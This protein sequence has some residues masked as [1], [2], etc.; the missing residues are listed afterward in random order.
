METAGKNDID[1]LHQKCGKD[2]SREEK[3]TPQTHLPPDHKIEGSEHHSRRSE[4]PKPGKQSAFFSSQDE[5]EA[6]E[7]AVVSSS[8]SP[9]DKRTKRSSSPDHN[10]HL[11]Q[12]ND[13]LR[14]QS[15]HQSVREAATSTT[16]FEDEFEKQ[17]HGN[18]NLGVTSSDGRPPSCGTPLGKI[19]EETSSNNRKVMLLGNAH[20]F[21]KPS[22]S[23]RNMTS[24]QAGNTNCNGE[25]RRYPIGNPHTQVDPHSRDGRYPFEPRTMNNAPGFSGSPIHSDIS[26]IPMS[27][28][29]SA[30]P[31]NYNSSLEFYMGGLSQGGLRSPTMSILSQARNLSPHHSI[32]EL[33]KLCYPYYNAHQSNMSVNG[34]QQNSNQSLPGNF[35][36]NINPLAYYQLMQQQQR[37]LAVAA[38]NDRNLA[39]SLEKQE[40]FGRFPSP[41][42][43]SRARKRPLS[44]SPCFSDTGLDITAMIR[45]SPNSLLP[46]GGLTNSRSSSVAS[47]GSYGHLAAGGI[48]PTFGYQTPMMTSPQ[49]LHAHLLSRQMQSSFAG[50]LM[51]GFPTNQGAFDKPNSRFDPNISTRNYLPHVG[52][53]AAS[54][55]MCNPH[56]DNKNFSKHS[57]DPQSPNVQFNN[58]NNNSNSIPGIS[59]GGHGANEENDVVYDTNCSWVNCSLEFDTQEQLV[60]HINNDHIHGDKKEFVCRWI[61]CA[62]DQRPFKAQYMLVVHMRR[63]TGEKPH[64]CTFEG[65][66]KAYS[67]LENLKTHLRSHTGEKPYV[68]E[69][70]SCTKAFSNASDRAKHQNRTHSNEKPYACKQAGCTK[71]YTDPSSLRKHVKTVHGPEAH[72]TKRMKAERE[73]EGKREPNIKQEPG[74]DK[75]KRKGDAGG[76]KRTCHP[77]SP[78]SNPPSNDQNPPSNMNPRSNQSSCTSGSDVSV[79]PQN[80]PHM[81]SQ[82]N[83]SGVDVNVGANEGDSDGDIVVDENPQPDSTSGGVGVQSRHRGTV[84]ASLV[85]RLVN[86]KMQNLSIGGNIESYVDIGGYDDQRKL[87]MH[88]AESFTEVSSTTAFPAKQKNATFPRKL[89]LTPH[90]QV[91]LLNQDRRDSGTVSDGSRKSSLASQNSRRSSQNTGGINV[92]GSYDPISL[93]SSRRSSSNVTSGSSALNPY[94]LHRLRSRFNEN[95]GLPPPTPVDREG[96]T[97]SQL[98]RW[99]KDD[100]PIP[101]RGGYLYNPQQRPSLPQMGPP[102]PPMEDRRRSEPRSSA[103]TPLPPHLGG[104]VAFRRASDPTRKSPQ[105]DPTRL[106]N[107]QRHNSWN[108]IHPLPGIKPQG[109]A[110]PGAVPCNPSNQP[111]MQQ[112]QRQR[113]ISNSSNYYGGESGYHSHGSNMALHQPSYQVNEQVLMENFNNDV[114]NGDVTYNGQVYGKSDHWHQQT[115]PHPHQTMTPASV[116]SMPP[117]QRFPQNGHINQ[118]PFPRSF[119]NNPNVGPNKGVQDANATRYYGNPHFNPNAQ[120]GGQVHGH[121]TMRPQ[122]MTQ[123]NVTQQFGNP[124]F[125]QLPYNAPSPYIAQRQSVQNQGRSPN[126]I[127]SGNVEMHLGHQNRTANQITPRPPVSS[128]SSNQNRMRLQ[129]VRQSGS[130]SVT[131][132]NQ[133]P[134]VTSQSNGQAGRTNYTP[135]AQIPD[136]FLQQEFIDSIPELHPETHRE[137]EPNENQPYVK[138]AADSTTGPDLDGITG[139]FCYQDDDAMSGTNTDVTLPPMSA[140]SS[141]MATPMMGKYP[142]QIPTNQH[143]ASNMAINSMS[144]MLSTLE[145]ENKYLNLLPQ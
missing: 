26:L 87:G 61:G 38:R 32:Q 107:V 95:A 67:R 89:P 71:R 114:I 49:H 24:S 140:F 98:S 80:S 10:E 69:Y 31:F 134:S 76:T 35:S 48:S 113:S 94:Q 36:Q 135:D 8:T 56:R 101:D 145:E 2:F 117:H 143:P 102:K 120:M 125:M 123:Q 5:N 30:N 12:Q 138:M 60:H 121:P 99:L 41:L 44:I 19:K 132:Y 37:L 1:V 83:D 72:V 84:R 90:R 68:C 78:G 141:R 110:Y 11:R 93:D 29:Q 103:R 70:P 105:M 22:P 142:P 119:N 17:F 46:F 92:A 3:A 129:R 65:C 108:S 97:K 144:S 118:N 21:T 45:T 42:C 55:D 18:E 137:N 33:E 4:A 111:P 115:T 14:H 77:L 25:D 128:T 131:S 27:P 15:R 82:N 139:N 73:R 86:K 40:D 74:M 34:A 63:H 81:T 43:R 16:T 130:S 91:A 6:R 112:V 79:T 133:A 136:E 47:G 64:R 62:R 66:S 58:N 39:L 20:Q 85:P 122:K 104:G 106:P 9:S 126:M 75:D 109:C 51:P 13:E 23:N 96:Y 127:N 53:S 28:Q 116:G 124:D 100:T 7:E 50:Q 59:P 54:N 57:V 52:A 88:K